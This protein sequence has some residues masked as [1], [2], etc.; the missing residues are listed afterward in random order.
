MLNSTTNS[1]NKR[2]WGNEDNQ[3]SGSASHLPV[4]LAA[5]ASVA[6]SA[7]TA[8]V[9]ST[10]FHAPE[11]NSVRKKLKVANESTFLSKE[12][13]ES[14]L[15]TWCNQKIGTPEHENRIEA[16]RRIKQC[17]QNNTP[18]LDLENLKLTSLGRIPIFWVVT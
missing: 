18:Q 16:A 13:F 9:P 12:E 11:I 3:G 2:R 17:F 15:Q 7:S 10:V 14:N 8:A 4:A 6:E 1:L 5:L